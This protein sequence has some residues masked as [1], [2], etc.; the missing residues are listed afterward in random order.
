MRSR[1]HAWWCESSS[2]WATLLFVIAYT[3]TLVVGSLAITAWALAGLTALVAAGLV[4]YIGLIVVIAIRLFGV[5][6]TTT[7]KTNYRRPEAALFKE[8]FHA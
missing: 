3:A 2:V 5:P 4:L 8:G 1:L 7:P 6:P